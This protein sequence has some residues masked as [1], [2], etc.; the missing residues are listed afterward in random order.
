MKHNGRDIILKN[1][2]YHPSFHNLISRQRVLGIELKNLDGRKV[3]TNGEILCSIEQDAGTMWIRREDMINTYISV[4]K[5][6]LMDLHERHGHISFDMLKSLPEAQKYQGTT[7]PKYG[8]L[9]V[10]NSQ[11][12]YFTQIKL[13]RV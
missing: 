1:V 3:L 10:Q 6:T 13:G 8:G 5:V 9:D 4:N 7:T 11:K 12:S 2:V